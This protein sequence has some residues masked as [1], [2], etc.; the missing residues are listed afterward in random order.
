LRI[1]IF[2]TIKISCIL[3]FASASFAQ[4]KIAASA[5]STC[6]TIQAF[7]LSAR[8]PLFSTTTDIS[9]ELP[10]AGIISLRIYD[11]NGKLVRT[12]SNDQLV[13]GWHHFAWN[14][15]SDSGAPLP[16]GYY[17]CIANGLGKSDFAKIDLV[18]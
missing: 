8:P 12:L 2:T 17:T 9:F 13:S 16:S 15:T 5:D 3:L 10:E 4:N 11:I 1:N 6:P 18:R 7:N 14:G